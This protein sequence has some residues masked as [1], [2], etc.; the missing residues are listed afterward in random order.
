MSWDTGLEKDSPAYALASDSSKCIRVVAGPGT[1]KSFGLQRR[2]AKLLEGGVPPQ[3]IFAVT[4][5]KLA[6]T[7]MKKEILATGIKGA[8]KIVVKTLHNYCYGVLLQ[9]EVFEQIG[10]FPRPILEYELEPMIFDLDN[11][12]FGN[13]KEKKKRLSFYES[14][15]AQNQTSECDC[16]SESTENKEFDAELVKWLKNHNAMLF[17]EIIDETYR[18]L[19]NNPECEER[20]RFEHVLVDEYQD[21]NEKE[22]ALIELIASE[23]LMIIGDDDQSIYSYKHA[24]PKGIRNFL[25]NHPECKDITFDYCRRCPKN[26]VSIASNLINH[27]SNRTLGILNPFEKNPEG[28]I[29]IIQWKNLRD[30]IEGIAD[31]IQTELKS[32]KI[33]PEDILVLSPNEN[34]GILLQNELNK[35]QIEARSYFR[36]DVVL[37][38]DFKYYFAVLNCVANPNDFVS[39]RYLIG[40]NSPSFEFKSYAR[41]R[42]YSIKSGISIRDVFDKILSGDIKIPYTKNIS[43]IYENEIFLIQKIR[44][45]LKR[46]RKRIFSL[47]PIGDILEES[48]NEIGYM[49]NISL[50]EWLTKIHYLIIGKVSFQGNISQEKH[51]KI[52]SLRASKGL[53]SKFIVIA[54][55]SDQF[56]SERVQNEKEAR[57]LFYVALTRC[58]STPEYQGKLIISSFESL[59]VYDINRLN[60]PSK[61]RL[62]EFFLTK[63]IYE[64]GIAAPL[65]ERPKKL[66]K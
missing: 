28:D 25:K 56:L 17:N 45:A 22:Q 52:M 35:K 18:Y 14:C 48:V 16:Y 2:V 15:L 51:V 53:S 12:K 31:I 20:H 11:P 4:F 38:S 34:V 59:S 61:Y 39:L 3:R 27:N 66:K 24:S 23:N 37:D 19:L 55:C 30:E 46:D 36:E 49:E 21:L 50:E 47:L 8:D 26:V 29:Q 40:R 42:S 5:T 64:L 60:F 58:K 10:R 63:H 43:G 41:I 62:C 13:I 54:G 1:G 6:A 57:R 32:E 65:T 44:N 33:N 9:K 7:D